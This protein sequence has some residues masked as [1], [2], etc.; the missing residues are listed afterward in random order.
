VRLKTASSFCVTTIYWKPA[1]TTSLLD[2]PSVSRE[3]FFK[4]T[5]ISSCMMTLVRSVVL[6]RQRLVFTWTFWTYALGARHLTSCTLKGISFFFGS[7]RTLRDLDDVTPLLR[8][9]MTSSRPLRLHVD[10]GLRDMGTHGSPPA[11]VPEVPVK[12]T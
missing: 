3:T 12:W 9:D 8:L 6:Q 5:M 11:R 10:R 2:L 1:S 7:P 4:A